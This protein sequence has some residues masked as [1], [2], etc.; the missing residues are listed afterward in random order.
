ML[1]VR[2]YQQGDFAA[3]RNL[4]FDPF[5]LFGENA[6]LI[7]NGLRTIW[8]EDYRVCCT[9]YASFMP[10]V[11]GS[12]A[13]VD[14]VAAEGKGRELVSLIKGLIE[15]WRI[16]CGCHR[17]EAT[18]QSQDRTAQVFLRAIGYR[19]E[20]VIEAGAPDGSDLHQY[21]IIIRGSHDGRN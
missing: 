13:A 20:S 9:G 15:K 7:F 14:R 8:Y 19:F 1:E 12:F 17:I 21:K 6:E 16:E 2:P 18:C 3:L 5:L 11:V 10:G 4:A